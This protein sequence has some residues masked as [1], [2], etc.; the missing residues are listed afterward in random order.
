MNGPE[1]AG[2]W[3]ERRDPGLWPGLT[4]AAFQAAASDPEGVVY[5]TGRRPFRFIQAAPCAIKNKKKNI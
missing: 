5:A 1:R 3:R 2:A 4:E